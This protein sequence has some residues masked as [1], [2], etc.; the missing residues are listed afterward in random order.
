MGGGAAAG[1]NGTAGAA[2]GTGAAAG[3]A[4]AST[5][6]YTGAAAPQAIGGFAS[7]L[8]GVFSFLGML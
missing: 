2:G 6:I 4:S 8:L 7:G 1:G 5:A 3:T